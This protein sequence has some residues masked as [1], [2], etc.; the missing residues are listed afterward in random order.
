MLTARGYIKFFANGQ[1]HRDLNLFGFVAHNYNYCLVK[2]GKLIL[3][4]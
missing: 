1:S 4:L 3:S 2:G